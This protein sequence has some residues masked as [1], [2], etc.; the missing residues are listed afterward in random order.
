LSSS[1]R[2]LGAAA[3]RKE[4]DGDSWKI[5][6]RTAA[7]HE[8]AATFVLREGEVI[9]GKSDAFVDEKH[10]GLRVRD[11]MRKVAVI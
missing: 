6:A 5:H 2:I 7:D 3:D 9:P 8:I 10:R 1:D 4:R 11:V